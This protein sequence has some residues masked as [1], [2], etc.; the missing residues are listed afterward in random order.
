VDKLSYSILKE[1]T[2]TPI[3]NGTSKLL[4]IRDLPVIQQ[5][6]NSFSSEKLPPKFIENDE[7]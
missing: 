3:A 5:T 6:F 2:T 7:P 1:R 4:R